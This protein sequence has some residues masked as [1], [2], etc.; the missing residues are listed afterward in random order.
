MSH[1]RLQYPH[2]QADIGEEADVRASFFRFLFFQQP[3]AFP[4]VLM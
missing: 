4:L 1:Q 2:L 3:Q